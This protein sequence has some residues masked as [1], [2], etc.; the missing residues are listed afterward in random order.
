M[1]NC[2]KRKRFSDRSRDTRAEVQKKLV[3][4][5][6]YVEGDNNLP[7]DTRIRLR[8]FVLSAQTLFL[9][10]K[11][12]YLHF[13]LVF[14][15]FSFSL[16]F[17]LFSLSLSSNLSSSTFSLPVFLSFFSRFFIISI[18]VFLFSRI[19]HVVSS[20]LSSF[21]KPLNFNDFISFHFVLFSFACNLY[22]TFV[23]LFV[24]N[25]QVI[26]QKKIY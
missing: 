18:D 20:V 12:I 21:K 10:K 4:E 5:V 7:S 3:I 17:S 25:N 24:S 6:Y 9:Q 8:G 19:F 26:L 11:K 15:N 13:I 14:F 22:V 16:Q 2:I 23:K 1:G